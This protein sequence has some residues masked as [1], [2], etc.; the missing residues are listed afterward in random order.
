MN[1]WGRIHSVERLAK[2]DNPAIKDWMLRE[3]FK[4][5]VMYEYSAYTCAVAGNLRHA[6]ERDRI[7]D[8]LLI[9]TA[10]LLAALITGGP[11][12][13]I[14]GYEDGVAVV[15][16]FLRLMDSRAKTFDQFVALQSIKDFVADDKTE[17]ATLEALGWTDAVRSKLA[18]Q[19]GSI[20]QRPYWKELVAEGL[21]SSDTVVFHQANQV[22]RALG[23]DT[24]STHWD[25]LQ[26]NP[27][28]SGRWYEVMALSDDEKI[29]QI[30]LLAEETIPFDEIATGP[31]DEMGF[32]Q[33]FEPHRCL[34]C[35]LQE[36]GRFPG[37]GVR[38]AE[39]GLKSPVVRNR[40]LATK[41]MAV[42]G[43]V[44]WPPALEAALRQ[45]L[46]AEPQDDVRKR[47]QNVLDGKPLDDS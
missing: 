35:L 31:G 1:G 13:G 40:N 25:R 6:L 28:E 32:G 2:T 30:L 22:A 11:V 3:G 4:N 24:W 21:N 23:I 38:L 45:A 44:Q 17:W 15:E 8:D 27:T 33:K 7:D 16:M 36:L 12:Q 14:T 9:S 20:M 37:K 46:A 42:W 41:V 29:G 43:Q 18:E 10:E 34:D 5:A 47:M 39:A 26:K 19:C